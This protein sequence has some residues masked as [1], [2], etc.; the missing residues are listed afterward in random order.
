MWSHDL[1]DKTSLQ[2]Q[3]QAFLIQTAVALTL[4]DREIIGQIHQEL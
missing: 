2:G 4:E 3:T 1:L